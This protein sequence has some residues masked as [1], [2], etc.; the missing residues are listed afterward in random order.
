MFTLVGYFLLDAN[1]PKHKI[2]GN[3]ISKRNRNRIECNCN[4]N[5]YD[6]NVI[7]NKILLF[8]KQK[9]MKSNSTNN[10]LLDQLFKISKSDESISDF[11]ID[12]GSPFNSNQ[13]NETVF[14]GTH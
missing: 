13:E 6:S 14:N 4:D 1:V 11:L 10:I 3:N 9:E 12:C 7:Y 5:F 8:E 2:Y